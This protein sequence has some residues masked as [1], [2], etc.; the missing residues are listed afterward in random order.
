[1]NRILYCI[2]ESLRSLIQGKVM[3][4]ISVI[5]IAIALFVVTV[6]LIGILNM[7]KWFLAQEKSAT[8]SIYFSDT[9]SDTTVRSLADELSLQFPREA[10]LYSS[11][12]DEY[13][14]FEKKMGAELLGEIEGNPFGAALYI[15]SLSETPTAGFLTALRGVGGVEDV[16]YRNEWIR[17]LQQLR[18]TI[19]WGVSIG[20]IVVSVLVS[21]TVS[22]TV[23]LTVYAREDLIKNMQYIGASDWYIKTPFILEGVLQGIAGSLFAWLGVVILGFL[24]SSYL[25]WMDRV[26]LLGIMVLFGVVVGFVG[27]LRSVGKFFN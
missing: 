7:D 13:A 24:L 9:L 21:F 8:L 27:S 25:L 12:E 5:T 14:L 17:K 2:K 16:V 22:N 11:P 26:I 18:E 15:D 20:I 19:L 4:L 1:M 10:T 6:P 23:K 3:T